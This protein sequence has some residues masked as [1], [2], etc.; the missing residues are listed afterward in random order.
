MRTRRRDAGRGVRTA[1][2][3]VVD[4]WE[5]ACRVR[6]VHDAG[7]DSGPCR[8]ADPESPTRK[9]TRATPGWGRAHQRR[10]RRDAC[11]DDDAN[12]Q[13]A[14]V[15]TL[16]V[17]QRVRACGLSAASEIPRRRLPRAIREPSSSRELALHTSPPTPRSVRLLAHTATRG[18]PPVFTTMRLSALFIAFFALFALL[19]GAAPARADDTAEDAPASDVPDFSKMKVREL[20]AILADRGLEAA[21]APKKG[22]RRHG[23]R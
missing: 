10:F 11:V 15:D 2:E 9:G 13:H 8:L 5:R 16:G 1:S 23:S 6:R 12:S 7:R 21:A 22:L 17:G 4:V 3:G 19:A 20:L 14:K 18:G